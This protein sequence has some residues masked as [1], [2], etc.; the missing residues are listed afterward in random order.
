MYVFL[1]IEKKIKLY[2]YQQLQD[3]HQSFLEAQ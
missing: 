3:Q 2:T 1:H